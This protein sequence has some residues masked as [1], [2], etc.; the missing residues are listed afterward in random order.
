LESGDQNTKFFQNYANHRK[1]INTIWEMP[2]PEGVK[3]RGFKAWPTYFKILLSEP[4]GVNI[5]EILKVIS[6]FP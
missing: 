6:F 5:G 2:N 3:V 1:N 4:A